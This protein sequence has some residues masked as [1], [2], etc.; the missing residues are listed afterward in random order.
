MKI[1]F[2][3]DKMDYFFVSF[4]YNNIIVYMQNDSEISEP[5]IEFK[6]VKSQIDECDLNTIKKTFN[7]LNKDMCV[8]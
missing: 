2:K 3:E 7:F 8:N 1:I 4:I 5:Y 6:Y